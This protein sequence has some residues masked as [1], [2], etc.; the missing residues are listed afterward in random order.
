MAQRQGT[1]NF[2][3]WACHFERSEKSGPTLRCVKGESPPQE[4][5]I[6]PMTNQKLPPDGPE[7]K[8]LF[9]KLDHTIEENYVIIHRR[10]KLERLR[11]A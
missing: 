10:E 9:E 5:S 11:A 6:Q 8:A 7:D 4:Q 2:S 1:I 3:F